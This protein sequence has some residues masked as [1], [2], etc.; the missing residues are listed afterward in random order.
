RQV[1][2]VELAGTAEVSR[3]EET[4][5]DEKPERRAS[6]LVELGVGTLV[7]GAISGT[8]EWLLIAREIRVVS[9][10][11]GDVEEVLQAYSAGT[12][13][14]DRFAM[15]GCCTRRQRRRRGRCRDRRRT[16]N[17]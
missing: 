4:L 9:R 11:C 13:S 17:E 5:L 6:R 7:C 15:P 10:I 16:P 8:L 14:D 2:L 3:R 12:L 1:L